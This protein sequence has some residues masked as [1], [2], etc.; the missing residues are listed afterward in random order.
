MTDE[1]VLVLV[2]GAVFVYALLAFT[3]YS[4]YQ[5]D[6]K[7]LTQGECAALA[8][9]WPLRLMWWVGRIITKALAWLATDFGVDLGRAMRTLNGK[10]DVD[11]TP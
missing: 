9:I 7:E 10:R 8:I 2:E 1:Q 5:N 3:V 6:H 11:D 4:F